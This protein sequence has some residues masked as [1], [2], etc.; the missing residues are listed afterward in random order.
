[1][2]RLAEAARVQAKK[3]N[4]TDENE[5]IARPILKLPRYDSRLSEICGPAPEKRPSEQ[6]WEIVWG[7]V[8]S[9]SPQT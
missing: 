8:V 4:D 5:R 7:V 2:F 3:G 6:R 9:A 1:M